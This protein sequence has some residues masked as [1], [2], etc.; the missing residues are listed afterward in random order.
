M[1]AAKAR[2]TRE[3]RITQ[4]I[5]KQEAKII[6]I[7]Q[8]RVTNAKHT[9]IPIRISEVNKKKITNNLERRK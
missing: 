7:P 3:E 5:E 8:N 6:E 2:G 1:G 9:L 4:A